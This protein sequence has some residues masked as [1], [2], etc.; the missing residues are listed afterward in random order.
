MPL[1]AIAAGAAKGLKG[2]AK[3]VQALGKGI[4]KG[5]KKGPPPFAPPTEAAEAEREE[6][7]EEETARKSMAL[8]R[9]EGIAMMSLAGILDLIGL[10]CLILD[11][12]FGV[13]EI[14]SWISDGVGIIFVGGW[15]FFRA[16][17]VEVPERVKRGV[18]KGLRKLF[19]GKWKKFL[20]PVIGEVAP[21]VGALPFWTISVYFEL[22][23]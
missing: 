23:S 13:G 14:P 5:A 15:M 2:V 11:I 7:P 4:G 10:I 20:T 12:F 9:P 6:T 17:R 22:T 8:L 16:G 3:G 18:D 21:F 19:R 1:P